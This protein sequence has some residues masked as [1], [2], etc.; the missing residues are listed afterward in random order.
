MHINKDSFNTNQSVLRMLL[1]IFHTVRK[2]FFTSK[3]ITA[4]NIILLVIGVRAKNG[5]EGRVA[6]TVKTPAVTLQHHHVYF[7]VEISCRAGSLDGS[8]LTV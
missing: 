4:M 7:I 1:F 8:L 5:S 2:E 6:G 3:I